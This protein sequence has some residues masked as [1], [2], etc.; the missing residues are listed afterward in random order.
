MAHLWHRLVASLRGASLATGLVGLVA[1]LMFAT[2]ASVFAGQSSREALDLEDLARAESERLTELQNDNA[3]LRESIQPYLDG[4]S[5]TDAPGAGAE[6]DAFAAGRQPVRGPGLQVELWDAPAEAR[7][8]ELAPDALVVH[9][10]DLE[11]V[12]NALWGGGAEAMAVQGHRVVSTTG[13][14]CVGNVLHI[15]GR[16]Y[17][18]PYRIEAIGDPDQLHEALLADPGVQI[19]QQYVD[20]VGLGWS[21]RDV[22]RMHLPAFEG[23][24]VL[25]QA[26]VLAP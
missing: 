20:A 12:M 7:T 21:V 4:Q 22:E 1:G 19:Y 11:A 10:Q 26:Q 23:S 18:P 9:Q 14:R 5:T 6:L 3:A 17:S 8:G 15:E 16:T 2:S 13:V 25:H 24:L